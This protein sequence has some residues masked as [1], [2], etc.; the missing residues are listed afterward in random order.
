[1]NA[2]YVEAEKEKVMLEKTKDWKE[3]TVTVL[4]HQTRTG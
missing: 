3:D 4:N 2:R 1:M